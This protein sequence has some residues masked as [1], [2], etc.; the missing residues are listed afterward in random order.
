MFIVTND[1]G[2]FPERAS[3]SIHQLQYALEERQF[4]KGEGEVGF[5]QSSVG[6]GNDDSGNAAS[7]E[8]Q[9]SHAGKITLEANSLKIIRNCTNFNRK[10]KYFLVI[11]FLISS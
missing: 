2:V 7:Q 4:A 9:H 6:K 3:E 10:S 1:V 11:R 8:L 5:D